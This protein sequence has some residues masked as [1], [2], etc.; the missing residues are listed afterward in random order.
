[1]QIQT[2]GEILNQHFGL[3][4]GHKIGKSM[5]GGN[6]LIFSSWNYETEQ[7]VVIWH[8]TGSLDKGYYYFHC[9]REVVRAVA[10]A[11]DLQFT[12]I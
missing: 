2:L 8:S 7:T 4:F 11:N 12:D 9:S 10:E 5:K 1:M 3:E 6:P